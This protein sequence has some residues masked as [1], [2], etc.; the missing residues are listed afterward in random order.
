MMAT[1]HPKATIL[2]K[3]LVISYGQ[4]GGGGKGDRIG[5]SPV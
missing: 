1:I 5:K 3:G 4:G 2:T